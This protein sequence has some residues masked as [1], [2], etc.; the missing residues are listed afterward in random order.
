MGFDV[1]GSHATGQKGEYFRNS[2]WWWRPLWEF[3]TEYADDCLTQEQLHDG[4]YNSGMAVSANDASALAKRLKDLVRSGEARGYQAQRQTML[5]ALPDE[6]CEFC[7]QGVTTEAVGKKYPAYQPHIGK[8]C[9][10]CK[11][12]GTREPFDKGYVFSVRNVVEFA[13]FCEASGGFE[14]W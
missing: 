3:I 12:K 5:D 4:N 9:I 10:Q 2:V 13:H 6:P 11:G 14:V 8:P 7:E 1:Y